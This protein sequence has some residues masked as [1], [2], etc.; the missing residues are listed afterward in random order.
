MKCHIGVDAGG[1]LVHTIGV[2]AANA[3]DVPVATKL[4]REDDEAIYGNSGYLGIQGV[5]GY[6]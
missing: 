6:G 4:I 1:G 3:H 5:R 2:T